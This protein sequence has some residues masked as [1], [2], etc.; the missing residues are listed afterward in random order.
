MK[1]RILTSWPVRAKPPLKNHLGLFGAALSKTAQVEIKLK[2]AH[3][4]DSAE[5]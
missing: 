2:V 3:D 1:P 5:D 4:S